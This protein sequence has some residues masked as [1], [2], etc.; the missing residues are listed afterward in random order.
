MSNNL[1][2][3]KCRFDLGVTFFYRNI[4]QFANWTIARGGKRKKWKWVAE[5][6]HVRREWD[7]RWLRSRWKIFSTRTMRSWV[8]FCPGF[9]LRA[10]RFK[11]SAYFQ[12]R[13]LAGFLRKSNIFNGIFL[14]SSASRLEEKREKWKRYHLLTPATKVSLQ[15]LSSP[16]S[17]CWTIFSSLINLDFICHWRY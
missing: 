1:R 11:G 3:H 12:R 10:E 6:L 15:L 8:S 14:R 17:I 16:V 9:L 13:E 5:K 4:T 2:S 7:D